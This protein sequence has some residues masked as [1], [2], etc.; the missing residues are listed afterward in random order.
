[1]KIEK[2]GTFFICLYLF[3][4]LSLVSIITICCALRDYTSFSNQ[5]IS[6]FTQNAEIDLGL[7]E[8]DKTLGKY[9]KVVLY[10]PIEKYQADFKKFKSLVT[11]LCKGAIPKS[12]LLNDLA[13]YYKTCILGIDIGSE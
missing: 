7:K 10:S 13:E 1:M 11:G 2:I 8:D 6:F 4:G 12:G 9:E 5:L 3:L